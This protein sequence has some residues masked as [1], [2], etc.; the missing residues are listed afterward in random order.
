[1]PDQ[2]RAEKN[3]TLAELE[4]SRGIL[5]RRLKQHQGR[6]LAVIKEALSFAGEPKE[7]DEF[8]LG[9]SYTLPGRA[10]DMDWKHKT[11]GEDDED[12]LIGS[13][14]KPHRTGKSLFSNDK[15]RPSR[16]LF[17]NLK[18]RLLTFLN[19]RLVRVSGKC[20]F[21]VAGAAAVLTLSNVAHRNNICGR[22]LASSN[23]RQRTVACPKNWTPVQSGGQ[24]CMLMEPF[25]EES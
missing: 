14:K 8:L 25:K 24:R 19:R 4:E 16:S 5:I 15:H 21:A 2:Q 10:L 13:R 17:N 20:M 6:E 23:G 1:M 22:K 11:V 18:S 7:D 3:A 9:R 12:V